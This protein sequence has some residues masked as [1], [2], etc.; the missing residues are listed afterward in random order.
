MNG[1]NERFFRA[2]LNVL[3]DEQ[4]MRII[5]CTKKNAKSMNEIIQETNIAR[6]TVHRKIS[7]MVDDGLLYVENFT[8]SKDGKKSMLF[9][10][11]ISNIQIKHERDNIILMI[12]ENPS[13]TSKLMVHPRENGAGRTTGENGPSPS[14]EPETLTITYL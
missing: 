10:G 12:E 2:V 7:S 6:T 14:T 9:R 1:N 8:I 13:R 4:S 5:H 3:S 11:R